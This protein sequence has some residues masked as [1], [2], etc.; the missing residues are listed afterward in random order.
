MIAPNMRPASQRGAT[1]LEWWMGY[2]A[3]VAMP[4][5]VALARG[6]PGQPVNSALGESLWTVV[7]VLAA[8]RLWTMRAEVGAL[9]RRSGVLWAFIGLMFASVAWSVNAAVTFKDAVELAGTTLVAYYLVLR[10]PLARLLELFGAAFATIAALSYLFIVI[11]PSRSRMN[12]GSGAW[13]GI[14]Q[15]KNNLAAAMVLAIITFSILVFTGSRKQRMFAAIGWIAC[16]V[17]LLGSQSATAFAAGISAITI[18]VAAWF[19]RSPRCGPASR[20]AIAAVGSL[21]VGSLLLFGFQPDMVAQML[22][23]SATLT[24]RTDFWPY[25]LEAVADRPI[26]GFGYEAFFKSSEGTGYLG[27]YVEQAGGWTPYHAHN[28]FLQIT[29]D[30]G[31]VAL[32]LLIVLL[33]VVIVRA[34]RYLTTERGAVAAW[35][36]IVVLYLVLGSYTETYLGDFNTLEWVFL[37]AAF[38]CPVRVRL[39]GSDAARR[40]S[41]RSQTATLH[42]VRHHP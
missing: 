27:D 17:L 33:L 39:G 37:V 9:L 21:I 14:F 8:A 16:F 6:A 19:W 30:G 41:R 28:S 40:R 18:G 10:Y 13:C 7:Y 31:I 35:P 4:L 22:G 2:G 29:L 25:L 24:G 15:E 32:I 5:V 3:L 23:R 38:L 11:A 26:L 20:F 42:A 36:L 34:L 1:G 12:F